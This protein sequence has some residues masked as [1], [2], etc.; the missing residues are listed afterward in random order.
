MTLSAPPLLSRSELLDASIEFTKRHFFRILRA[1]LPAVLLA[2]LV[3][4]VITAVAQGSDAG[5]LG[6]PLSLL[7]WGVAEGMALAACWNLVQGN[8]VTAASGWQLVRGRLWAVAA[9]Y[10]LKWLGI[11]V[12]LALLIV[13]GVLLLAQWFAVPMVSVAEQATLKQ[14]FDR[15][16][17][18]TRLEMKRVV[19]TLGMLELGLMVAAV[20]VGLLVT[21]GGN[22]ESDFGYDVVGWVIGIALLPLRAAL[23]TLLYL[24]I[25]MRREAYDL[26]A[27]LQLLWRR[28]T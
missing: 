7:A 20:G 9:G 1:A 8:P 26:E 23:T 21:G 3:D 24:D 6:M 27:G 25:R 22:Q 4:L 2:A 10:A 13:P 17:R 15:S 14:A 16:I 18:L 28:S 11:M 19:W 5:I 12:G